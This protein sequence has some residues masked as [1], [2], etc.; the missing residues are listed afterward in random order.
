MPEK[1]IDVC[2]VYPST[3]T[4]SLISGLPVTVIRLFGN[5][6]QNDKNDIRIYATD[7][8]QPKRD[9]VN[10]KRMPVGELVKIINAIKAKEARFSWVITG[11]EPMLQQEA[12]EALIEQFKL[13]NGRAPSVQWETNG[14]IAPNKKIDELTTYYNVHVKLSNATGAASKESFAQRIRGDA[15]TSYVKNPKST[16]YFLAKNGTDLKEVAEIQRMFH[17]DSARIVLMPQGLEFSQFKTQGPVIQMACVKNGYRFM[18]R[19]ELLLYGTK[20]GV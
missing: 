7:T 11:G 17:I 10:F 9:N 6:F 12:V 13:V 2:E 5:N 3:Q 18:M 8:K 14:M 15:M 16:F 20:R 1:L 4:L 19:S